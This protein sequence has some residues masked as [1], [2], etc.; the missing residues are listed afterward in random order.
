MASSPIVTQKII[1]SSRDTGLIEAVAALQFHS[2]RLW[3]PRFSSILSGVLRHD[4]K[5]RE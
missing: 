2:N 5:A 1:D 3:H 4:A